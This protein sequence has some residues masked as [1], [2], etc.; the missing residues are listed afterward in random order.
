MYPAA[1][2]AKTETELHRG[3]A[4]DASAARQ[5]RR[6]STPTSR[7]SG[8]ENAEIGRESAMPEHGVGAADQREDVIGAPCAVTASPQQSRCH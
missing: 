1:P 8:G 5:G 4:I 6:I 3:E 7:H 2:S